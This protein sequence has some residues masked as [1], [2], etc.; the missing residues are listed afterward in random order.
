MGWPVYLLTSWST[1]IILLA[2]AAT[3][4][5]VSVLGSLPRLHHLFVLPSFAADHARHTAE[6]QFMAHGIHLTEARTGVL[7]YVGLTDRRVEIVA[8][9][10]INRKVSQDE[11]DEMAR[12]IE[13]A[14]R[15]GRLP[16]GI[17]RVVGQAG[18]LLANHFPVLPG[19]LNELADRVVEI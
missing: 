13:S 14:A 10:G 11:W 19:D 9:A 2:Q 16:E 4:A 5:V 3:F 18:D 6:T 17:V 15:Q 8:D 12:A 1:P 7:I